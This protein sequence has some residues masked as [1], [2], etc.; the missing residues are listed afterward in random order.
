MWVNTPLLSSNICNHIPRGVYAS[1]VT[2]KPQSIVVIGGVA[3]GMSAATRLRRLLEEASITVLE[4]SGHVSF[5]NCGLPYYVGGVIEQRRSLLLQTPESLWDRFRLDV[6]VRHEAVRVDTFTRVVTARDLDSGTEFDLPFDA[7]VLSPGARAV[8]PPIPG[9]ERALS[10]R[11]IEDTDAMHSAVARAQ[12][13]V[14][15]GG[16]FIG[17]EMAENL[18][19]RGLAVTVVE[20]AAQVMASVDPEMARI[21]VDALEAE[22]IAVELGASAA[23]ITDAGVVLADGRLVQGDVVVAAIGVKPDTTVA[24]EAGIGIGEFGGILVD[25]QLRTSAP[26]VW[27]VGD[28]VQKKRP[29]GSQ[30]L[31]PLAGPANRQGRLA[32]DSIAGLEPVNPPAY[33]TA[34]VGV[35]GLQVAATGYNE[36]TLRAARHPH[37]VIHTHPLDHAGYYPGAQGLTL[38]LLVDAETDKILGA[39]AIGA[40]GADKRV[41]VIATAMAGGL[42]ASQLLDL[43]LSYAPQFGSAKDPVNMLGYIDDNQNRGLITAVQWHDVDDLAVEGA[44]LLDVRTEGEFANGTIPGAVNVPLDELRERMDEVPTDRDIVVFCAVGQRG[45]TA[46]RLLAQHGRT[47]RNLDGGIKTWTAGVE[48]Q[49]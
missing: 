38:K 16:G 42:T 22:G 15:I 47:V 2:T 39:Q 49:A 26:G 4:R 23:E 31:V 34:I 44:M 18:R 45:N 3:G 12:S 32:A 17:L 20:A 48:S 19:H 46:S 43:D 37:Q 29:D 21:V 24:R 28:A 33:G 35:C 14:V 6:R 11:D 27:A 40:D 8:R 7:L 10:L 5:A 13:A 36:K 41:D 9:I 30:G 25:D 1:S